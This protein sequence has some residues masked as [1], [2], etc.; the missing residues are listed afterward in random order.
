MVPAL[1]IIW[2]LPVVL[3][4]AMVAGWLLSRLEL[5]SRRHGHPASKPGV[6]Q[7]RYRR[8]A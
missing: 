7:Q 1:N 5:R 8:A 2:V 3:V 6:D 4:M